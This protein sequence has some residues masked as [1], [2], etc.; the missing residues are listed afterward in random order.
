MANLNILGSFRKGFRQ[1]SGLEFQK[2]R[3]RAE[4]PLKTESVRPELTVSIIPPF[5]KKRKSPGK[6]IDKR[7]QIRENMRTLNKTSKIF[8]LFHRLKW[9][10]YCK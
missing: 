9:A 7:K 2:R 10:N 3:T 4:S 1:G 8:Q 6:K 5:R